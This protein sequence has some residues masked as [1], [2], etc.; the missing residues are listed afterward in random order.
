MAINLVLKSGRGIFPLPTVRTIRAD[1]AGTLHSAWQRE[2]G[3]PSAGPSSGPTR[4]L[5]YERLAECVCSPGGLLVGRT[6]FWSEDWKQI[7]PSFPA[8]ASCCF[9]F[10]GTLFLKCWDYWQVLWCHH[11]KIFV[12]LCLL[13]PFFPPLLTLETDFLLA[14]L[15]EDFWDPMRLDGIANKLITQKCCFSMLCLKNIRLV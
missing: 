10:A 13:V 9:L 3:C 7:V 2:W 6:A 1:S 15:F 5:L 4:W 11:E 8:G 14:I 12:F